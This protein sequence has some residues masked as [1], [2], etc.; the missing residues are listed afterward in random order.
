MF[1]PIGTRVI[2]S[3]PPATTKSCC[4]AATVAAAKLSACWLDPHARVI[5]VP[6]T[7]EGHPAAST[8]LRAT[9]PACSEYCMTVPHTTS[10]TRA[11]SI[12]VR[13]ASAPSTCADR[14]TGWTS[15]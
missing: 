7:E 6:G 14:S 13:V 4:P 10:S 8:A 12:P 9:F 15:A 3:A 11:G 2:D 5:V 1:E